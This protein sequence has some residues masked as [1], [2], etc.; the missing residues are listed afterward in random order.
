MHFFIYSR[1][2]GSYSRSRPP[3]AHVTDQGNMSYDSR[4]QTKAQTFQNLLWHISQKVCQPQPHSVSKIKPNF[5][6]THEMSDKKEVYPL[7]QYGS[8]GCGASL[9]AFQSRRFSYLVQDLL[10][11]KAA[12]TFLNLGAAGRCHMTQI[13]CGQ[14]Y[15]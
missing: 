7:L 9:T 11:Q 8:V 5:S 10:G 3:T 14:C 13:P 4:R 15:I 2:A 12:V 6:K 1:S